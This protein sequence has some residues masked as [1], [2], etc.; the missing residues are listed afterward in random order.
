MKVI[1]L[2]D[3]QK[4]GKRYDVKDLSEGYA[5]NV[6]ISRGLAVLAT[7]AE[8][9]KLK[10]KL[11]GMNKKREEEAKIFDNLISEVNDKV[12]TIEARENG[13]GHLFKQVSAA[14]IKDA[15][16]KVSGV[17]INIDDIVPGH[18]KEVGTYKV[19]IKRG[20]KE[21]SCSIIVKGI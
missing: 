11:A 8:L 21:G 15:I 13:K 14:D 16:L 10:D 1:L 19:K 4:V 5:Q 6:L 17:Q 20:D 3:V 12:V 9:A 2:Q 7:P 18:I